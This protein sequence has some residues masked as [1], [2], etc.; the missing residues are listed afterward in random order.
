MCTSFG[1]LQGGASGDHAAKEKRN[2]HQASAAVIMQNWSNNRPRDEARTT[3]GAWNQRRIAKGMQM[4]ERMLKW[5]PP[6]AKQGWDHRPMVDMVKCH[7]QSFEHEFTQ[8]VIRREPAICTRSRR[9]ESNI[10]CHPKRAVDENV[11]T[12]IQVL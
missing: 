5:A 9:H 7:L 12:S 8:F 1:T 2:R 10:L 3:A 4:N 6:S 11:Q